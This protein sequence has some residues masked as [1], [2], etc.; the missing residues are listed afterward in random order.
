MRFLNITTRCFRDIIKYW[1]ECW[2]LCGIVAAVLCISFFLVRIC[3]VKNGV[4]HRSWKDSVRRL[5]LYVCDG[6]YV[7]YVFYVTLGM[8]YIGQRREVQWV[9]FKTVWSNP[10][11]IPLL[12]ENALVFVPFGILLP[13]TCRRFS[14]WKRVAACSLSVSVLIEVSQYIFHCGKTETDDVIL[15][16][17]GSMVGYALLCA[18]KGILRATGFCERGR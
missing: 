4:A 1:S 3:A 18:G 13:L 8:R 7:T 6:V 9:P 14:G 17:L 5:L 11:E 16:V 10:W 2:R 12:V 15:N